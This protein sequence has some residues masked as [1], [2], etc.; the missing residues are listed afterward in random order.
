MVRCLPILALLLTGCPAAQP[1]PTPTDAGTGGI[2]ATEPVTLTLKVAGFRS[3]AGTARMA[4]FTGPEGFPADHGQAA[5]TWVGKI[6][7]GQV[8]LSLPEMAP[9]AYAIAVIHDENDNG[10]LDT[11]LLGVPAEG[12]GVSNDPAPGMG[13]PAFDQ[14]RFDLDPDDPVVEIEMRYF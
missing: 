6:L 9:G 12:F 14:A 2:V 7:L 1:Q 13:P 5:H 3:E 4:V 8:Q 10:K 11:N